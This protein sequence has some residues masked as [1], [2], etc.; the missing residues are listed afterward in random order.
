[1]SVHHAG[2]LPDDTDYVNA[3]LPPLIFDVDGGLTSTEAPR[4]RHYLPRW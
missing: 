4:R 3:A 1:M 2:F